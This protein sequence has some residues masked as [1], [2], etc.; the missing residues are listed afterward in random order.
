MK[1]NFNLR[2]AGILL[3]LFLT[4]EFA[5]SGNNYAVRGR[6]N[7]GNGTCI[8]QITGLTQ[9]QKD[10]M[11]ELLKN[12]QQAMN[13]LREQRRSTTDLAQKDQIGKQ[14][15]TEVTNHRNAIRALLNEDQQKQFDQLVPAWKGQIGRGG[16]GTLARCGNGQGWRNGQGFRGR[17]NGNGRCCGCGFGRNNN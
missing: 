10:Q 17:G 4:A 3:A 2:F 13:N 14:M 12:H 8:N 5:F 15:D 1:T 11:S 9:T 7:P 6:N 16:K